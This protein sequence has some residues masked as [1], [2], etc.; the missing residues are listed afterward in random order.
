MTTWYLLRTSEIH[1]EY[2]AVAQ[3]AVTLRELLPQIKQSFEEL[4]E[5]LGW[6]QDKGVR[7]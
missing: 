4:D 3:H 7:S 2:Q 1:H 6:A 5:F